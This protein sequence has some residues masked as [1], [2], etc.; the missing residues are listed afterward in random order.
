MLKQISQNESCVKAHMNH[1][2]HLGGKRDAEHSNTSGMGFIKRHNEQPITRQIRRSLCSPTFGGK[3]HG[4]EDERERERERE[5]E[6]E[7]IIKGCL[8]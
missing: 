3:D 8:I 5:S 6:R 7:N 2:N 1:A 4:R